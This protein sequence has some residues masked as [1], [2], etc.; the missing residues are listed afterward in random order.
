MKLQM[1]SIHFNA[2]IK[3]LNFIRKRVDKLETFYD[4]II[5][6]EV[7]LRV[8]NDNSKENKIVEIKLNGPKN[9]FFSKQKSKSF[10]AGVDAAVESLRR[11]LK[12]H[13]EKLLA[14]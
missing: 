8:E 5:D 7:F 10:E 9:Q 14:H 12:K 3:L 11:Q 2:D 4:R 6:G 13:K 1:H